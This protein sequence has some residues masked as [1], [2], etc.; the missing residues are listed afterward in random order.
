MNTVRILATAAIAVAM[1]ATS[2]L[3]QQTQRV[4]GTIEKVDGNTLLIKSSDGAPITLTLADNALIVGVTKATIAD[5]KEGS[6]IGSGALPQPDGTQKAVEVH[7]FAESQRGTGD[8]HRN[9]WDGAPGGTMT[10]G[11]V[12]QTVSSVDGP[13]ITVKYKDGEKKVIVG[14]SVPIVRYEIGDRSELTPGAAISVTAAT[15]K[16]DG[17]F[18]SARVNVGRGGVVPM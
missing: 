15:K 8:G 13:V 3:A 5:I 17:T 12:G 4:R 1:T 10:N 18:T 7:I 14:P 9:N 6:Y 2:A 11:A 16:P